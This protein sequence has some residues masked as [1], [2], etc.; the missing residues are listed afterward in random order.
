[1][2]R[3]HE[4]KWA[5]RSTNWWYREDEKNLSPLPDGSQAWHPASRSPLQQRRQANSW[6]K[7]QDTWWESSSSARRDWWRS[8]PSSASQH[9]CSD[10]VLPQVWKG[11]WPESSVPSSWS[12]VSPSVS[13]C[14]QNTSSAVART[15]KNT[16]SEKVPDSNPKGK[17][18]SETFLHMQPEGDAPDSHIIISAPRPMRMSLQVP[19]IDPSGPTSGR[20]LELL[21]ICGAVYVA[22]GWADH[23]GRRKRTRSED[24]VTASVMS[25]NIEPAFEKWQDLLKEARCC[26]S[27]WI[28]RY[29]VHGR[30]LRLSGRED[31]SQTLPGNEKAYEPDQRVAF[32][33]SDSSAKSCSINWDDLSWIVDGYN[34][35]KEAV[36]LLFEEEAMPILS[37]DVGKRE[38]LSVK[39]RRGQESWGQSC[40]RHCIYP[41]AGTCSQHTDYGVLTLQFSNG[42]GLEAWVDGCWQKLEPPEGFSLLF[43]G[44]M[45]ERLTNGQV[46]ALL[47]R[48]RM[49]EQKQPEIAHC[50]SRPMFSEKRFPCERVVRQSHIFFLQ[51]DSDSLV[52]PLTRYRANDGTDLQPVRYGDWHKAKVN[53]AFDSKWLHGSSGWQ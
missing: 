16:P 12:A 34:Q 8:Y 29:C 43:A 31:L 38:C 17:E 27:H 39:L 22:P 42:P 9:D 19:C 52:A 2:R 46:K 36:A 14:R 35:L 47:H 1:M 53:L 41:A 51:P 18:I 26:P 20:L 4:D 13:S 23:V 49:P 44:D 33:V 10:E 32:G 50:T 37:E 45:L 28:S 25:L 5:D 48:V 3:W 11:L 30:H 15:P 7:G 6:L 40:L 21:E 24:A